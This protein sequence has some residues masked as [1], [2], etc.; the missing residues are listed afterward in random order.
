M[1][2]YNHH[3]YACRL[4]TIFS[5]LF[6][7]CCLYSSLATAAAT[8]PTRPLRLIVPYA[9]GGNIDISARIIATPL[10]DLLGQSVVVDNRP[11]AGGNLGAALVAKAAPDGYT[12]LVG[13]SGPLSVNPVIFKSLP[14]DSLKDFAPIST[15]QAVPL[16]VIA[17]P[18]SSIN[19]IAEMG[20]EVVMVVVT[21]VQEHTYF[22]NIHIAVDGVE[23]VISARPSD[24]IALA[25]RAEVPVFVESD[26]MDKVGKSAITAEESDEE[27]ILDDFREFI[28]SINP[29][30]F[31]G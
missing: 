12:I 31:Q 28:N 24:A 13:S 15:I 30:D 26:L 16:V 7:A 19:T 29:E 10:A 27:E 20:G 17:G 2:C 3:S 22:A 9:P 14:Y 8:F 1:N 6:A 11:G 5:G 18:K 4:L 23:R 25:V 21:D